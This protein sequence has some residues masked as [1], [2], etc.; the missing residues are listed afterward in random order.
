VLDTSNVFITTTVESIGL[1]ALDEV[2]ISWEKSSLVEAI[3]LFEADNLLEIAK[4]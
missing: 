4:F 2:P 3:E 1:I